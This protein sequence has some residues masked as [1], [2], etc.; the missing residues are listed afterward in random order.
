MTK[1]TTAD[2][3]TV[4]AAPEDAQLAYQRG[5]VEMSGP[6]QL[7][8]GNEAGE[9]DSADLPTALAQGW[10]IATPEQ[11]R[12]AKIRGE[13][14]GIVGDVRGTAEALGRG[15]TMGGT[16]WLARQAGADMEAMQARR[17]QI[18]GGAVTAELLGA[19]APALL[20]G[21]TGAVAGL[22]ARSPAGAVARL[23]T[24][25][26]ETT[27]GGRV[28]QFAAQGAVEGFFG[29]AGNV[30]T[31]DSLGDRD[32]SAERVLAGGAQGAV[33]G[34]LLGGGMGAAGDGLAA[35]AR[36]GNRVSRGAIDRLTG[37]AD[38]MSPGLKADGG[39]AGRVQD[40]QILAMGGKTS[41][42]ADARYLRNLTRT[43]EGR[44]MMRD[45]ASKR[46][47]DEIV[48][49]RIGKHAPS[50]SLDGE[51]ARWE[52]SLA[53]EAKIGTKGAQETA[54]RVEQWVAKHQQPV[55]GVAP[56]SDASAARIRKIL[57]ANKGD[58]VQ[59]PAAAHRWMNNVS[60]EM[61]RYA[62]DLA[63]IGAREAKPIGDMV[64]A[65]QR[66]MDDPLIWGPKAADARKLYQLRD[67]E[68]AAIGKLPKKLRDMSDG[69]KLARYPEVVSEVVGARKQ[70]A[71]VLEKQ[72]ADMTK[73]RRGIED[74][75]RALKS[76]GDLRRVSDAMNNLQSLERGP[77]GYGARKVL[78]GVGGLV[79]GGVGGLPGLFLGKLGGEAVGL[80]TRPMAAIQTMARLRQVVDAVAGREAAIVK[81][82]ERLAEGGAK[83][84]KQATR[85]G[86]RGV[87]AAAGKADDKKPHTKT[88]RARAVEQVRR[89]VVQLSSRPE[90][91]PDRLGPGMNEIRAVAPKLAETMGVRASLAVA[92]LSSKLPPAY[93]PPFSNKV[94]VDP[95]ALERFGRYA[96][97]VTDPIGVIEG[98]ESGGFSLEHAEA[99]RAVYPSIYRKV[100]GDVM[101]MVGR[102][103]QDGKPLSHLARVRLGTLLQIPLDASQRPGF[104][105]A[106]HRPP[107][108]PQQPAPQASN[109]RTNGPVEESPRAQTTRA[110]TLEIGGVRD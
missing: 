59:S 110:Q 83:A 60:K 43:A 72:G 88:A 92:F 94:I 39:I 97:A 13:Q 61:G 48:G 36:G 42:V 19:A 23:G 100:Q 41:Q 33:M 82:A 57:R 71:A 74:V 47:I 90:E 12:Q 73:V 98:L 64:E 22:A 34:G 6:V 87:R 69:A 99:L 32:L 53:K 102:R 35:V 37:V 55:G 52:R 109:V 101:E 20:T 50:T 26:A 28:A 93:S 14:Q 67:M 27:G 62:D 5:Q 63:A 9:V 51:M 44:A 7:V 86:A 106:L 95:V 10:E 66:T 81:G 54:E 80:A 40:A 11:Q 85:S 108:Q 24:L 77:R 4:E 15:L 31:E 1:V 3:R 70:I 46:G 56:L 78:E 17:A 29:G 89:T 16:D 91:V 38:D 8:R 65:M 76:R 25:A 103:A 18:G 105:E 104:A 107:A 49:A 68:Q 84:A 96:D 79:G 30:I 58:L 75:E 21:G 2:G 45:A